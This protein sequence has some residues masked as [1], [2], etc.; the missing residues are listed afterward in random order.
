M[1]QSDVSTT[2]YP[3]S[4]VR[5]DDPASIRQAVEAAGALD[6]IKPGD[7]VFLKPNVVFWAKG[8][9]FP[10]WGVVTSSTVVEEAVRLVKDAGAGRVIIGEGMV[11]PKPGDRETPADAFES[12]G[13]NKLA[14]RYGVEVYSV[15]E[16]PFEKVG[17]DDG[18]HLNFSADYLNSDFVVSLPVLKTHAQAVV[19]LSIKNLK[20]LIDVASRKKCHAASK[21]KNL[22]YMLARLTT[23]LPPAATIIDGIYTLEYGPGFDG[24]AR[25][26]NLI[27]ASPDLLAAD[28]IGSAVLGHSPTSIP[29]LVQA[30]RLAGRP[31]DLSDAEPIGLTVDE[32]TSFHPALFPYTEDGALPV[33]MA[34]MG[35]TGLTYR[36]Y[37]DT[38]CTYCS[39]LNGV[40]L[41]AIARAW[42]GAPFDDIEVLTGKR[43]Q[44]SPGK[45]HTV[46]IG[47]CICQANK[48]SG[49]I[50]HRV[51]IK[52]CPPQVGQVIKAFHDL[53]V[54]LEPAILENMADAPAAFLKRYRGK[55][56]F[57]D[58]FYRIEG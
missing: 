27:I 41:S 38:M 30:A 48:D 43:M 16:R 36:K 50:N 57:E 17:L 47:K 23:A 6:R 8:L 35:L 37:D 13:Y 7:T 32:A 34:K 46:L 54:P 39:F 52:G 56:E 9:P 55:A 12:L 33:P 40:L 26:S 53:G 19:S 42:N 22:D 25:R 5:G 2:T 44:A 49:Q 1:P 10:K 45:K 20:G 18:Q 14:A 4:I 15:F 51:E 11:T 28:K 21:D 58:R 24:R 29:H 3:V 31:A